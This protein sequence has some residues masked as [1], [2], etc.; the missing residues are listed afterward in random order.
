L[1]N[2]IEEI[3]NGFLENN[4]NLMK[5]IVESIDIVQQVEQRENSADR[6]SLREQ[7]RDAREQVGVLTKGTQEI[8][9]SGLSSDEAK[10][11]LKNDL[12]GLTS[13]IDEGSQSLVDYRWNLVNV[14][15]EKV[16]I[17]QQVEQ[18]KN[19]GD[20]SS[21]REQMSDAREQV[22]VLTKGTQEI[23]AGRLSSDEAKK[24]LKNNLTGLT[25][26]IDEGSQSLV[27]Y[28]WNLVNVVAKKVNIVQQVEQRKNSGDR[29]SLGEQMSDAR[30]QVGVLTKGTQEIAASGFLR[31]TIDST[32]QLLKDNLTSFSCSVEDGSECLVDDR[33]N[34]MNIIRQLVNI[35]EQVQDGQSCAQVSIVCSTSQGRQDI[36]TGQERTERSC[37]AVSLA[38][39][40]IACAK[41][42]TA[43]TCWNRGAFAIRA[44]LDV[45]GAHNGSTVN[46]F[47][48]AG[49][50]RW[51]ASTCW[52]R[53]GF[54]IRANLKI[55]CAKDIHAI[56]SQWQSTMCD[57][58][59]DE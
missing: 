33:G 46:R 37:W 13:T 14:V 59:G 34:L 41:A 40:G 11:L 55:H 56:W 29:R 22:G 15:A 9:A 2:T 36:A 32:N 31:S 12:T 51:A 58:K 30:E 7:M 3:L 42:G 52:N 18:R 54:T 53:S 10:K 50:Q 23:A 49:A 39:S 4:R 45:H 16:N 57:S 25:S 38:D 24:L 21:L 17:V 47:D 48:S 1:L 27:D 5:I 35:V 43:A 6:S 20:R 8:A 28:Q 44:D 26:T 19:G